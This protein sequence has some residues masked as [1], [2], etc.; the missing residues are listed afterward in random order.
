MSQKRS[1]EVGCKILIVIAMIA[2]AMVS[3]GA[4]AE[5]NRQSHRSG[6]AVKTNFVSGAQLSAKEVKQVLEV[7]RLCGVDAPSE[8]STYHYIPAG[9]KGI[10]VKSVDRVDARNT[11]FDTI[12]IS[13]M[14]WDYRKPEKGIT[15]V[16]DFWAYPREKYSTL[17]RRFELKNGII[18]IQIGDDVNIAFADKVIPLIDRGNIRFVNDWIRQDFKELKD[19]K[20]VSI[21]KS[22]IS[23][24]YELRFDGHSRRL[25]I[26]D[27]KDGGIIVTGVGRIHV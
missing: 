4:L 26:F 12:I 22:H 13:K 21:L 3:F 25:L 9:G 10:S 17:L 5:T 18:Q 11:S 19:L 16:G 8:I 15:R 24:G 20:P 1:A 14:G 7:A 2:A 27:W 6:L 23:Q